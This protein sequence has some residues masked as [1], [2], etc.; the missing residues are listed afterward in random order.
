MEIEMDDFSGF[1]PREMRTNPETTSKISQLIAK[2]QYKEIL[3]LSETLPNTK[4]KYLLR[5]NAYLYLKK[6]KELLE[7]CDK[8]LDIAEE[9]NSSDF[10]NLKGK[11]VG[12]MGDHEAKVNLTLK[13]IQIKPTVPAYH[14]NLGAAYYKLKYYEKAIESHL[15]SIELEPLNSINYH[16]LGA[17]YFRLQKYEKAEQNFAKAFELN[18]NQMTSAA[19]LA[20]SQRELGKF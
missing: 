20:D 5:A 2:K 12:Q 19:W 15:K 13:A 3:E 7:T 18:K 16:N 6:W 17:A 8:G 11:A 9:E 1:N 14:R 10:Y 4:D